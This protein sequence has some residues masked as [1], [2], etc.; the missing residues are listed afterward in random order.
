MHGE[1][2]AQRFLQHA[3]R[4]LHDGSL[5]RL[6][7]SSPRRPAA[8]PDVLKAVL[9]RPVQLKAGLRLSLT[10]QYPTRDEVKNYEPVEGL[11]QLEALLPHFQSGYLSSTRGDWQWQHGHD[12][13]RLIAH[14]PRITQAP[15]P[16]HDL[17]KQ[18]W[19]D[20]SAQDWLHGLGI[21]TATGQV[22]ARHADKHRQVARFVEIMAHLAQAAGWGPPTTPAPLT[23]A[24]MGCGKGYLT[25]GV[26]HLFRR[27]WQWPVQVIG[28]E[29]RPELVQQTNQLARQIGA[30][31]L[32]FQAGA[33]ADTPLAR[34]DTL[35][36]LHAC[37]TATD[38]A[39]L[40]GIQAGAR[41]LVVAPCCHKQIRPQLGKPAPLAPILRHGLMAGRLAEWLTDGLR[42][43]YLEW[44]GYQ[45]RVVEFVPSEHTPRNLMLCGVRRHPPFRRSA[46]REQIL[47]LKSFFGIQRHALDPLLDHQPT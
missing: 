33:I 16:Q 23:L 28:V 2:A 5:V 22:A 14:P 47:A 25:F 42:A 41:L 21:T 37:D 9:A 11:R 1:N 34:L 20:P 32:S 39:L 36:A 26:W 44:A 12:G 15:S 13:G 4:C 40:K 6:R 17:G 38:E 24:D 18:T 27:R 19:L 45:T 8:G 35:I 10:R 31:G 43:L 7:L 3:A 46:L 30:E 29:Q